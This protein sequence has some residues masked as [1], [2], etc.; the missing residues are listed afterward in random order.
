MLRDTDLAAGELGLVEMQDAS[1][2]GLGFVE[3]CRP[4]AGTE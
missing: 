2:A 1:S 3:K 4:P